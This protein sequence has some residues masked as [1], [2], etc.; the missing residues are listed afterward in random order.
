MIAAYRG[1]SVVSRAIQFLNWGPY[2]HV[3]WVDVE[4]W[5]IE[6]WIYGVR[7][8]SVAHSN[9]TPGTPVEI[10]DAN[11]TPGE[12][13]GIRQFLLS[14]VGKQYDLRGVLHFV[15]R[16]P[17]NASDQDRWF[18]SELIHAA[19]RHVRR[20]LLL[21]VESW[22]VFPSMIVYSPLLTPVEPKTP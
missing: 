3:S 20:D 9:H 21:R 15:T 2:S 10:Y 5:E 22:K 14:Q 1:K 6:A 4:G 19:F 18:C 12:T 7:K 11:L 17:Q 13:D 8:V 16:R